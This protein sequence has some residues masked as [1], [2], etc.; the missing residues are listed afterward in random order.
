MDFHKDEELIKRL[1][2]GDNEAFNELYEKYYKPL[3]Y[4]ACRLT[5][6]IEDAKD[7]VQSAFM[8]MYTSIH[9]LKEPKYFR[10]WMSDR[11]V[12]SIFKI[13]IASFK[14]IF[15]SFIKLR[16]LSVAISIRPSERPSTS[17]KILRKC[18]RF[19]S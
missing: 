17:F 6:N 18:I 11:M 13:F 15:I 4:T 7:A 2:S 9:N 19:G 16:T 3:L 5:N 10:L 14:V 12:S 8:Q 1:Q